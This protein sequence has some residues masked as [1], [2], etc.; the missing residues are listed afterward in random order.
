[1]ALANVERKKPASRHA[2]ALGEGSGQGSAG[3]LEKMGAGAG[4]GA[5]GGEW[6]V[7]SGERLEGPRATLVHY[8]TN[9]TVSVTVT[10]LSALSTCIMCDFGR[11][12]DFSSVRRTT[13]LSP[14]PPPFVDQQFAAVRSLQS[15]RRPSLEHHCLLKAE[16]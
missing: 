15:A 11:M 4:A 3:E 14:T 16:A 13:Y 12:G 10:L 1:M 2:S 8:V 6:K 9:V 5:G 7:E